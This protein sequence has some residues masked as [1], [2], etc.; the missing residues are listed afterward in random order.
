MRT[1]KDGLKGDDVRRGRCRLRFGRRRLTRT[2]SRIPPSIARI[3]LPIITAQFGRQHGFGNE[4]LQ[5]IGD[6]SRH[7]PIPLLPR[8]DSDLAELPLELLAVGSQVARIVDVG[9]VDEL[10]HQLEDLGVATGVAAFDLQLAQTEDRIEQPGATLQ[11]G[12]KTF[13]HQRL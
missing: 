6:E 11:R 1:L 13:K 5:S 12:K 8:I 9:V 2:G 10:L 7:S 3:L 4:A